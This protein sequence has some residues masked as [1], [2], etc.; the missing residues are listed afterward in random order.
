MRIVSLISSATE[1]LC[2]LGL[3]DQL[4]GISHECDYPG[5]IRGLPQLSQPRL[6][7][8]LPSQAIHEEVQERVRKGLSLYE[9]DT[10]QLASLKPDLVITQD[11]CDVCAVSLKD[12]EAAVCSWTGQQTRL[13]S[14][15]PYTLEEIEESFLQVGAAT[16]RVKEAQE[17]RHRFRAKLDAVR[18]AVIPAAA[19]PRVLNLEWLQPPIVGGG[20]IP[21]LVRVAGGV[22]L[23]VSD[24]DHFL[25]VEWS[26]IES[27]NPEIIALYPCGFDVP[28]TLKEMKVPEVMSHLM[29]L[30]AVRDGKMFVCDGNAYFNRSGP[31]IADSCE[32]LSG[33]FH[34]E[35]CAE[36]RKKH[37]A[38]FTAWS[39]A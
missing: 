13:L 24:A 4:V 20:W 35:L 32:L 33:L 11:Q 9:I 16:N 14:L 21:E 5:S 23:I 28:R 37:R 3:R 17:L 27:I 38:F 29:R 30:S 12:V 2:E 6:N 31:R 7:P 8:S 10:E 18:Q 25:K 15:K 19:W 39:V 22:P 34:P 26:E 1:I 36:Y